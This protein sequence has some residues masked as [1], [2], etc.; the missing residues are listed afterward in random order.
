MTTNEEASPFHNLKTEVNRKDIFLTKLNEQEGEKINRT[1]HISFPNLK[2]ILGEKSIN[3]SPSRNQMTSNQISHFSRR[4]II[5]DLYEKLNSQETYSTILAKE[6]K[7]QK[8]SKEYTS[9]EMKQI[10]ERNSDKN[11]FL[12]D[13][14]KIHEIKSRE[15]N[16]QR[17][18]RFDK[19]SKINDDI[20]FKYREM[21]MDRY[22]MTAPKAD[23]IYFKLDPKEICDPKDKV[24]VYHEKVLCF[25]NLIKK[26]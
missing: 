18:L 6:I 4:E 16:E 15:T 13:A 17:V 2:E 26:K 24:N 25:F 7:L 10:E 20:V 5:K 12:E 14:L 1:K 19:V 22:K 3:I 8:R 9:T 23:L 11:I 21:I